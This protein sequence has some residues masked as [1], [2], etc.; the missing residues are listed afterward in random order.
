MLRLVLPLLALLSVASAGLPKGGKLLRP[1]YSEVSHSTFDDSE[2]D[3]TDRT[4][5]VYYPTPSRT[6]GA[7]RSFPL[8][9]FAHGYSGAFGPNYPLIDPLIDPS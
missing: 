6:G 2:Q 9:S 5:D 7:Q 3:R 4:L 8:I 1:H